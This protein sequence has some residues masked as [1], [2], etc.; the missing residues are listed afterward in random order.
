LDFHKV[1]QGWGGLL[2]LF[3]QELAHEKET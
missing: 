1:S 3:R 2:Y